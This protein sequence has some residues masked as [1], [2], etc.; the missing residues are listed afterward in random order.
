[1][2]PD[3]EVV[4]LNHV[5]R[6]TAKHL[7]SAWHQIPHVVQAVE[8][9]F[10]RVDAVRAARKE[11]FRQTHG[12]S[13]SYLPFIARAVVLAIAEFPRVNARFDGDRLLVSR[14]VHL[15]VAVDLSHEGLVVPVLR[16]ADELNVTGLANAIDRLVKRARAGELT[17][18]DLSSATYTISNN[19]SFGTLF[20][21]PIISAPQVAI[22]STDAVRKRPVVV[23]TEA[24]DAIM[25]RPVGV[26]AQ[27]FDHRA[28][29]G[30][31]SAAFLARLKDII[32][33]RD[34]AAEFA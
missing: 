3:D 16:N 11:A 2:R 13:L 32:E 9:D 33:T 8:I 22:L 23:E 31:Y 20:T 18:D 14:R 10:G 29:D 34:W 28:F 15:G 21:A 1:P 12:V 17:P 27:S 24:G 25:A 26:L 4:P 19:G 5:R 7:A 6:Q 30:A